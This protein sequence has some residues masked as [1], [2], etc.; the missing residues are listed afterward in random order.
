[1]PQA[2]IRHVFQ[3]KA[4]SKGV[5]PKLHKAALGSS[6]AEKML[7]IK[8]DHAADSVRQNDAFAAAHSHSAPGKHQPLLVCVL[9]YA[10]LLRK[11]NV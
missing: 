4:M 5:R 2:Y 6:D 7:G 9:Y 10:G 3:A 11:R 8:H 1:M